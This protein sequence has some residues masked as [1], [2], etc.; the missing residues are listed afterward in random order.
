M[1]KLSRVLDGPHLVT[2]VR[3]CLFY[4]QKQLFPVEERKPE[5]IDGGFRAEG[6]TCQW[7]L[8]PE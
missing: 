1:F 5:V 8:F 7:G 6:I 4:A 2:C 3:C